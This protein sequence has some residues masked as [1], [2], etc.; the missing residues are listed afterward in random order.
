MLITRPEQPRYALRSQT[1]KVIEH[2][3]GEIELLW[4]TEALQFKIFDRHQ[5]LAT[6]RVADD[7]LL[8]AK[9]DAVLTKQATKLRNLQSKLTLERQTNKPPTK[10][11]ASLDRGG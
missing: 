10:N 6:T 8:N 9:V 2:L 11:W 4:A 7:K 1:V 3:D 5:H